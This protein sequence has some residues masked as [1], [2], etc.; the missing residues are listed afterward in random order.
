VSLSQAVR[1]ERNRR[2]RE[3]FQR[4]ERDILMVAE[5]LMSEQGVRQVSVDAI[6]ARTGIGKGT[7][8]KHFDSKHEV[9][10]ALAVRHFERLT[11]VLNQAPDPK[12]QLT[13][14]VEAQ[15][16]EPRRTGLVHE[17]LDVLQSTPEAVADIREARRRMR[18]RM[19]QIFGLSAAVKGSQ[20]TERAIWLEHIVQGALVEIRS[21]L[22]RADFDS[23]VLIES[24]VRLI[25]LI[26]SESKKTA[27]DD[28]MTYL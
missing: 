6:A 13:D 16:A 28:R 3:A 23:D 25:P 18:R 4:R 12:Q 17:L 8:Y 19:A 21:P 26:V 10:V 9:L 2:K 5:Q 15:L 11:V 20:A 24:V 27:A 22:R 7:I 14:W 1:D